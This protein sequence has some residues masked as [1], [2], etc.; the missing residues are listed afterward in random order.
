VCKFAGNKQALPWLNGPVSG[1]VFVS[2]ENEIIRSL[3]TSYD[4]ILS[5]IS[6][7]VE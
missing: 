4:I 6:V 1:T 5:I 7:F 3:F 2:A